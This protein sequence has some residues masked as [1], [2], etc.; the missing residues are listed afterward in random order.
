[1]GINAGYREDIL[2]G[3]DDVFY[4]KWNKL[5][6]G[7]YQKGSCTL[8]WLNDYTVLSCEV[9]VVHASRG[10]GVAKKLDDE[11]LRVA[12]SSGAKIMLAF[13]REDNTQ[14]I[15]A[16]QKTSVPWVPLLDWGDGVTLYKREL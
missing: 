15:H 14:Q 9:Y 10:R 16:M 7:H 4:N 5:P 2:L 11:K 8:L 3:D 13:V 6:L 1:M 12:R